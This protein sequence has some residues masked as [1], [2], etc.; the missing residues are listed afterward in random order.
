MSEEKKDVKL[1]ENEQKK[2]QAKEDVKS[3]YCDS[4]DCLHDCK[5]KSGKCDSHIV[6]FW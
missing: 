4:S 2:L 5:E 3:Q 1:N 6:S